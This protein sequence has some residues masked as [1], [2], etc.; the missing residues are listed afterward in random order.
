MAE[1]LGAE[2]TG[3]IPVDWMC[4]AQQ[5]MACCGWDLC[6]FAVWIDVQTLK[7]FVVDRDDEAI[8][9]LVQANLQLW[10]R[11]QAGSPPDY[12]P[13]QLNLDLVRKLY[14]EV[15]DE[16]VIMLSESGC[17]W[18]AKHQQFATEAREA[19]KESEEAK[20]MALAELGNVAYGILDTGRMVRR[21]MI[22]REPYMVYPK[23][24]VQAREM[25]IPP[26][27]ARLIEEEKHEQ[28]AIQHG[29]VHAI[30]GEGGGPAD[31]GHRH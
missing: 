23:P 2:G 5:Q 24:Y 15:H 30:G 22:E 8:E 31:P 16:E 11:I 13:S 19:R 9:M 27:V 7:T 20:A 12:D 6:H 14:R 4:Q 17:D 18:W 26:H 1:R 10:A 25:M 3:D 29:Q 21:K 28:A